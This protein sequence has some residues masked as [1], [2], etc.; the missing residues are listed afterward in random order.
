MNYERFTIKAQEALRDASGLASSRDHAEIAPEHLLQAL[1]TQDEG[2]VPALLDR[3]G[4]DRGA[5]EAELAKALSGFP[6][7]FGAAAQLYLS[8]QASKALAKA[9]AEVEE[10]ERT[11]PRLPDRPFVTGLVSFLHD[12]NA[13]LRWLM[14]TLMLHADVALFRWII[15]LSAGSG[16]AGGR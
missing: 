14:L 13:V 1:L 6:K 9:E 5:L 15:E 2:V 3:I 16:V 7:A 10:V 4:T 8:Q 12:S 11:K